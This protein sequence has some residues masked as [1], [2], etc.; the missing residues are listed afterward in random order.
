MIIVWNYTDYA[1]LDQNY[2]QGVWNW[3]G[4]AGAEVVIT[5][6]NRDATGINSLNRSATGINAL[7]R[8]ATG[9]NSL[10]RGVTGRAP[11]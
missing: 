3:S 8:S 10:N 7:N 1:Q 2:G 9:V 11:N 5:P 4:S 6:D